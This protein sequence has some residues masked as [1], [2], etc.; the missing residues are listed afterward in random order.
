MSEKS[1]ITGAFDRPTIV[2]LVF[3]AAVLAIAFAAYLPG[4]S[5]PLF[6]DDLPQLQ[7][8][9]DQ[10]ADDPGR[11]FT[12]YLSSSSGPLG[13]PVA[14]ATF[15]GSAIA[16]GPDTWWWKYDNLMLHL[17]CGLL[18][19]WCT[20]LLFAHVSRSEDANGWLAGGIVATFWMLH[21]L[22]VSTVLFAVQRMTELSTLFVMAGLIAYIKGR[23]RL[24]SG[25]IK[26]WLPVAIAFIL[27]FPLSVLS[28]ESALLFPAFCG[29]LEAFVFRFE[30]AAGDRVRLKVFHA[31]IVGVYG[32]AA[33]YVLLNFSALVLDAYAVR[34]FSLLERI[35]TELRVMVHYLSQLLLPAQGKMGFFHDDIQHSTSLIRPIT[36]LLSAIL[37][38]ALAAVAFKLRKRLPL[39][40]FGIAFFFAGHALESTVFALEL[41]F[42]HRNYLPS[43]GIVIAVAALLQAFVTHR[44][45]LLAFIVVGI[46]AFSFLTWQRSLTWASPATMYEFMYRVHPESPRLNL[47]FANFQTQAKNYDEARNFLAR[48]GTGLG[49]E[50]HGLFLDCLEHGSVDERKVRAIAGRSD[51]WVE[52][53][54]TSSLEVLVRSHLQNKCNLP[55]RAVIEMV[56]HLLQLP[57]RRSLDKKSLYTSKARMLESQGDVSAAVSAYR[58]AHDMQPDN[59]LSLYLAANALSTSGRL[60]E[61]ATLLS[62]AFAV[63]EAGGFQNKRVA[64]TMYLNLGALYAAENQFERALAVYSEGIASVPA[65]TLIHLKKAEMLIR[66]GRY[67][68]ARRVLANPR[69]LEAAETGEHMRSIQKLEDFLAGKQE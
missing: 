14:M 33:A 52:G 42:E 16:H 13:R 2:T 29:L 19:F 45:G 53:H 64:R 57:A 62:S 32:L 25:D 56:D 11:L 59:A 43:F 41:M 8:L 17:A 58:S 34:D 38:L 3:A 63:E 68:E 15:V 66:L 48:I 49:P 18:V 47:T 44:T 12:S 10:S 9:I 31:A 28:K 67:E 22:H 24:I 6:F 20:A 27:F 39:F 60:D 35:Y 69:M 40:T 1:R 26:G 51:G 4:L 54:V 36:T 23:Q 7:P 61:A 65:A 37:L 30:A 46:V 5:G 50:V 55:R 21:P